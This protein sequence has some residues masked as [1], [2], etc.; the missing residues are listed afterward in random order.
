[1]GFG[2]ISAFELYL[3]GRYREKESEIFENKAMH[4]LI[5]VSIFILLCF[6]VWIACHPILRWEYGLTW[7]HFSLHSKCI[8]VLY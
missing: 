1:M 3:V 5:K 6:L 2:Q 7:S 4:S 8:A